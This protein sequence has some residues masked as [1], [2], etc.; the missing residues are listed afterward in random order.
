M[1]CLFQGRL[2]GALE[3]IPSGMSPKAS[4]RI[5]L[6]VPPRIAKGVFPRILLNF[7]IL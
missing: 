7:P 1:D 4:R 6:A 5:T 3:R 2:S